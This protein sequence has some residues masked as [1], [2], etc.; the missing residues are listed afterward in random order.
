MAYTIDVHLSPEEVR[1]QMLADALKGL[2]GEQKSIPPVWF[3]DERG[4]RLFE[5]ITQ[6]PEYYPTRAERALLEAHAPSI[7][8]LSKAD[9]L[10]ELGAGACEK[11]R[12]LLTALQELGLLARYVPFDVS[13]EFLRSAAAT[14]ADEYDSLDIH[15]V[16]GDFHQHLAEIPQEGRRMIAFLGGTIGNLNPAQRARFLFDLNCTMSSDDSL[17]IGTDLVKDRN[18]LVAA[19]DD[20]AGV[21]ADFNRNVLYVLNEQLGGNFD[22]E[23]FRHV[24][25]WNEDEQWIEMRLRSD[26]ASEVSLAGAGITVRF[27]EGE[28]L[29]TEISAKF[30]PER[31][32]RELSEAGFVIEGMW[33]AEEGEFLLTLA[34]P[35]C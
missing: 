30:T 12:V 5:D 27:D 18:R 23:H 17:L 11:T 34:H 7:A 31:V 35:F 9:T 2:Q 3:Y 33:G 15:V 21:T 25:L 10:V 6:L 19:Y 8:E 24:A 1:S 20:A 22:P 13:D 29:L 26:A 28:D 16:I 4:S 14:L 32:E